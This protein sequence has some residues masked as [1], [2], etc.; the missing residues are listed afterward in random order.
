MEALSNLPGHNTFAGTTD[1]GGRRHGMR[2]V[3][4]AAALALL[5]AGGAARAQQAE[6]QP[7]PAGE[8]S[9]RYLKGDEVDYRDIT[10]PPPA[11]DSL[12]GRLDVEEVMALQTQASPARYAQAQADAEV[13]FPRFSLT[14]VSHSPLTCLSLACAP[15]SSR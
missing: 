5:A 13:L 11:D 10:G 1:R 7:R 2:A 12:M 8:T 15:T 6:A 4:A 9:P 3:L 14:L